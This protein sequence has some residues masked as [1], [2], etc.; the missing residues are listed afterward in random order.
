MKVKKKNKHDLWITVNTSVWDS[1]QGRPV[2]I[3]PP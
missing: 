3:S 1:A 2:S